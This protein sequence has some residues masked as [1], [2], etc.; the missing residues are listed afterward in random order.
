[1]NGEQPSDASP[2]SVLSAAGR[3]HGDRLVFVLLAS[4]LLHLALTLWINERGEVVEV[5][6]E[7]SELRGTFVHAATSA[8]GALPLGKGYEYFRQVASDVHAVLKFGTL[9]DTKDL[10]GL[11]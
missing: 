6:V 7:H 8:F 5:N 10:V 2:G 1:M 3:P 11:F 4:L 9:P